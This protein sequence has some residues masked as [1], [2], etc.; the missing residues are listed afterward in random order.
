MA[1]GSKIQPTTPFTRAFSAA[2]RD[3][4]SQREVTGKAVAAKIDRNPGFV[5]ERTSGKRP[6]DTD[7]LAGVAMVAGVSPQTIVRET[8]DAMK[9]AALTAATAEVL[10]APVRARG[11]RSARG[12]RR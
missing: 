12:P 1:D 2:L 10:P 5:S 11:T 6:C 3:V 7:I 8:L 9:L 4:M